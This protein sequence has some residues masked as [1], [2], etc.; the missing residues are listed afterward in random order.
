MFLVAIA[1]IVCAYRIYES[2]LFVFDEKI[3][4]NK[5]LSAW[6]WATWTVILMI[7]AVR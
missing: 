6:I 7:G 2:R 4:R 1:G 3:H 5:T